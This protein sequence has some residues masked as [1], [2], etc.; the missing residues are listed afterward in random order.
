MS[1]VNKGDIQM[2]VSFFLKF[3]CEKNKKTYEDI[4]NNNKNNNNKSNLDNC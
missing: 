1:P 2:I 3:N 4:N